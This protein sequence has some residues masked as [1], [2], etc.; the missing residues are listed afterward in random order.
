MLQTK[1]SPEAYRR[2]KSI[3]RKKGLSAYGIIQ[4]MCDC[5]IRYMDD[6]HNLSAEM[7]QVMS[8]FEHMDGWRDALNLADPAA[9]KEV[10]EATY[11]LYD[12]TGQRKG[13]RAVHVE[14]PF[15]GNW[16]EDENIQHILERTI[17]L[18]TPERYRRMRAIAVELGC[19]SQLELF[20]KFIDH[21]S[22][23]E[24]LAELR[25]VFEDADRAENNRPLV[26]GER[27][28]RKRAQHLNEQTTMF[29]DINDETDNRI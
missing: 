13:T 2:I 20:D 28:K 3:E 27:T 8:L 12:P 17:C 29:N 26:Y 5:I 1:V 11:F 21:F 6:R 14:K 9:E 16:S 18:L 23:E 24:D 4:M 10:G 19:A 15:F 22:K 25:R 7:E